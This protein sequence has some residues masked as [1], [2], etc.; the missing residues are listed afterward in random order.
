MPSIILE[1]DSHRLTWMLPSGKD[2]IT[3]KELKALI[4]EKT[5]GK[6]LYHERLKF[7][8]DKENFDDDAVLP[9]H[10]TVL[11]VTGPSSVMNMFALWSKNDGEGVPLVKESFP[12]R[13][14]FPQTIASKPLQPSSR[15]PLSSVGRQPL[16]SIGSVHR[17]PAQGRGHAGYP[18]VSRG[19]DQRQGLS[20]LNSHSRLEAPMSHQQLLHGGNEAAGM[21]EQATWAYATPPG[22]DVRAHQEAMLAAERQAAAQEERDFNAALYESQQLVQADEE[23]QLRWA[24]EE[25]AR[26]AEQDSRGRAQG[27]VIGD[28]DDIDDDEDDDDLPDRKSVV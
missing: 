16:S 28:D 12:Q 19:Y 14:P 13:K 1:V 24:L 18:Q 9:M 7:W 20:G 3:G 17:Y 25:S 22:V 10:P 26:L 8:H 21:Q 5:N 2:A 4:K 15:Q 27:D 23:A 6:I 11:K